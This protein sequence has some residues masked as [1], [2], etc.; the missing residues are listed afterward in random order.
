MEKVVQGTSAGVSPTTLRTA[1]ESQTVMSGAIADASQECSVLPLL[2]HGD[3]AIAVK[4]VADG[5]HLRQDEPSAR[6]LEIDGHHEDRQA[7]PFSR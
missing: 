2:H 1:W 7:D 3:R 6:R 5:L 4:A